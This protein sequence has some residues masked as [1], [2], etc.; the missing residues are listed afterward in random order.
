[1]LAYILNELRWLR[2]GREW[3]GVVNFAGKPFFS[4]DGRLFCIANRLFFV[5]MNKYWKILVEQSIDRRDQSID[6]VN[7]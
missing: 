1:M 4:G 3:T 6:P 5:K 2:V 7:F